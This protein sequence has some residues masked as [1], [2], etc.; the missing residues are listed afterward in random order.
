M[1]IAETLVTLAP[2]LANFLAA[3]YFS[4]E[5]GEWGESLGT[6]LL[7]SSISGAFDLIGGKLGDARQQKR[8]RQQFEEMAEQVIDAFEP[9]IKAEAAAMGEDECQQVLAAV[10][11]T[12]RHTPLNAEV[13]V[14]EQ[15]DIKQLHRYLLRSAAHTDGFS[16][17]QHDFYERF[18]RDIGEKVI[19]IAD[20]LP[21]YTSQVD[22]ALL[23][24]TSNTHKI[25][26]EVLERL[27]KI[28]EDAER[29]SPDQARQRFER[30][31]RNWV[32]QLESKLMIFGLDATQ[33]TRSLSLFTAH[34]PLQA[35]RVLRDERRSPDQPDQPRQEIK[36]ADEFICRHRRLCIVGDAGSGK[37]T[38][39]QWLAV[40]SS[41]GKFALREAWHKDGDVATQHT[42]LPFL[43]RL[44]K[45]VT[46]GLPAKDDWIATIASNLKGDVPQGWMREIFEQRR[47]WLMVDGVDEFPKDKFDKVQGWLNDLLALFPNL[48][49]IIT[50][51]PNAINTDGWQRWLQD[52][53]FERI[54]LQTLNTDQTQQLVRNWHAAVKNNLKDAAAHADLT[55]FEQRLL[56]ALTSD[57]PLQRL[58]TTPLL[59]AMLCVLNHK[60]GDRP[61]P[62][63]KHEIYAEACDVMIGKRD[64]ERDISDALKLTLET[65]KALLSGLALRMMRNNYAE[66][67]KSWVITQLRKLLP[68]AC[69]E[70][71]PPGA[72]KVLQVL[73]ERTGL[74]REPVH[75][76][77]DFVHRSFQEYLTA[78]AIV[79][80][81]EYGLLDDK[82][83]NNDWH[84]VIAMTCAIANRKGREQVVGKL[85]DQ[86]DKNANLAEQYRLCLLAGHGAGTG[87]Q[88]EHKLNVQLS[89]ALK[90]LYCPIDRVESQRWAL[91][92]NRAI[93]Y[94]KPNKKQ[95]PWQKAGCI[96]ALAGIGSEEALGV[97]ASYAK[98]T[99]PEDW[100]CASAFADAWQVFD[101]ERYKTQVLTHVKYLIF[102]DW[103]S[104]REL[105]DLDGLSKLQSLYLSFTKVS[106]AGLAT[107][108]GLSSLQSLNLSFTKVSD[109]GLAALGGL[110]GLQSLN[111]SS[112]QVSDAGLA[113]LGGLSGLKSLDLSYTKVSDAGLVALCEMS[114]L[115]SLN[116]SYTQ[117][118]DAGLAVLSEL[119][120]LQSLGF[121]NIQVSDVGL[122]ALGGL[123]GLKSLDLSYTQ[124]S[125]AGLA[126]LNRLS[127]L[128]S[129][130]VSS[131]QV[132]D[133]RL[134]TLAGLHSLQF[135]S[136]SDT[137]VSDAGLASLGKLSDLKSLDL[138]NTL[139]SEVGLTVLGGLSGLQSLDLSVTK[140]SDAGL[141]ALGGLSGLQ[142]L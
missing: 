70:G 11:E 130:S 132:S 128:K 113:A 47:V 98:Q 105:D 54:E 67:G 85:L 73:I 64:Q 79:Q 15:L 115:Q 1:A 131:S 116:L 30:D 125:D 49:V 139:V 21:G 95:R 62:S 75:Q 24:N 99:A 39:L 74:I 122:A 69:G 26:Q 133:A 84:E 129:L 111:L 117:V 93:P 63:A 12:I 31:Y 5:W 10:I 81:E 88:L 91:L 121:S 53:A 7:S 50:S 52:N 56:Q 46:S 40:Q 119:S 20:S 33:Q 42:D 92:G 35:S 112:T 108:G 38:I 107:V 59:C 17:Q 27:R 55:R 87:Q 61:L 37:T 2:I 14:R 80:D 22:Y 23:T 89:A 136:L 78:Y 86:A 140:V 118:S 71:R 66:A 96:R 126:A 43:F 34:V 48:R 4:H 82:A 137:P 45:F 60:R 120:D 142:S 100:E 25:V 97:I 104:D 44:R 83:L 109:A 6:N 90:G 110:S 102:G 76:R 101:R 72:E 77:I 16:Q 32:N 134:E 58:A 8:L 3:K 123:S 135:L 141:A 57:V 65:R 9:M 106:D 18:L 41:E 114:S 36:S 19:H 28:Q 124:V 103:T 94:L 51:R 13:L 29:N 138:S 127:G 68:N